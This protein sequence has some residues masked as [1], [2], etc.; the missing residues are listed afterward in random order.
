MIHDFITDSIVIKH[1][2]RLADPHA[3]IQLSFLSCFLAL[4]VAR[5]LQYRT[6]PPRD[7]KHIADARPRAI[8][9]Q[10]A[11]IACRHVVVARTRLASAQGDDRVGLARVCEDKYSYY[12]VYIIKPLGTLIVYMI[13]K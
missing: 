8:L 12:E 3:L 5:P 10:V 13:F 7:G 4:A 6:T 9:A 2:V 11:T 1:S